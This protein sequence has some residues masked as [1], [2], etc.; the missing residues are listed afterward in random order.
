MAMTNTAMKCLIFRMKSHDK[1]EQIPA[2]S[3]LLELESEDR[4]EIW[5]GNIHDLLFL[6]ISEKQRVEVLNGAILLLGL[7][8]SLAQLIPPSSSGLY[9][10]M[11]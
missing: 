9:E 6:S 5:K 8:K 11:T 10:H 3:L 2:I 1:V 7:L 4:Q